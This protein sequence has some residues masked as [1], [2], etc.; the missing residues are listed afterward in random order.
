MEGGNFRERR[1]DGLDLLTG[2]GG[3][4]EPGRGDGGAGLGSRQTIPQRPRGPGQGVLCEQRCFPRCFL[5][6]IPRRDVKMQIPKLLP[7]TGMGPKTC[8]VRTAGVHASHQA[9]SKKEWLK[10]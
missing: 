4:A 9:S 3:H 7:R 6:R 8:I 1:A 10:C 5:R 2:K